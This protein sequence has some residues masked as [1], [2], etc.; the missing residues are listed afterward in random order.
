MLKIAHPAKF[1]K[2]EGTP[3]SVGSVSSVTMYNRLKQLD[4]KLIKIILRTLY[5]QFTFY[6][7]VCSVH[8]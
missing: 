5:S 8:T 6:L 2:F 7:C 4:F 3:T 1:S